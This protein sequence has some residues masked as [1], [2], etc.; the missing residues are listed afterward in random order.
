MKMTLGEHSRSLVDAESSP[1]GGSGRSL[2]DAESSPRQIRWA[3]PFLDAVRT[4]RLRITVRS[5][6]LLAVVLCSGVA[7]AKL[8]PAESVAD[9]EAH[10][11]AETLAWFATNQFGVT[12]IG[13]PADAQFDATGVSFAGGRIRLD[14]HLSLPPGASA[15]HPVPVFVFGDLSSTMDPSTRQ[16][17]TY[18]DVP[19]NRILACGYAYV[20]FNFNCVCPNAQRRWSKNDTDI[21]VHNDP[22]PYAGRLSDWCRGVIAWHATGDPERLDIRRGPTDWGMLGAWAWSFSRVMDWIERRPE[23]DAKKVAIAGHSRGGKAALWAG[24]QDTRFA[25]VIVNNSGCGGAR[26][27]GALGPGCETIYDSLYH[28]PNWYCPNYA[29]WAGRDADFGRC[30]HDSDDLLRTIAPRLLCV[31]SATEDYTAWPPGECEAWM[32]SRALWQAYGCVDR[33]HYHVRIGG[34]KLLPEDWE[35]YLQFAKRHG[36]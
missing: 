19:T 29:Q 11:R 8:P 13:L 35:H 2:V 21:D 17:L 26:M 33:T 23:L 5:L 30:G 12:P 28:N 32:R 1:R 6:G 36:W 15:A 22:A 4:L 7:V 18:P 24:A 20:H 3:H 10:G 9:W 14:I 34:H 31:A 27:H 16:Q 25:M